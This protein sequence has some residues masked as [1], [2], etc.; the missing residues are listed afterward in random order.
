MFKRSGTLGGIANNNIKM[1]VLIVI[2]RSVLERYSKSEDKKVREFAKKDKKIN[3]MHENEQKSIE[4]VFSKLKE[5]G[6][7]YDYLF[8]DELK[9]IKDVDLVI[10][11]GGD[12]TFL[13][14]SH[15][16][17][18]NTPLLG[19][20]SN[21]EVSIGFFCV[22]TAD[23]FSEYLDLKNKTTVNRLKLTLNGSELP[24]LVLND[25]LIAHTNPAATTLYE[26]DAQFYKSSGLL[27][28]TPAGSSGWSYQEGG[29]LLSLDSNKFIYVSRGLRKEEFKVT[30]KL[31]VKSLTR[32]GML[33][34]DGTHVSYPFTLEDVLIIEQGKP[35]S[36]VGNLEKQRAK[37][38]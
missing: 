34:I 29:N 21:P 23:N 12:G 10:A 20:N 33:F 37:F 26:I 32:K 9:E 13:D 7:K 25:L 22:S 16:I 4:K 19:I 27:V 2:K 18:D 17:K 38:K 36:I 6:V 3:S 31:T 1:K 14:V 15:F 28:S 8:R 5:L 11:L 35:I 24:T 30:D